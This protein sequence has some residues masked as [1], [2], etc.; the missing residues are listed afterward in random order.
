MM[1]T[2]LQ[3]LPTGQIAQSLR[4][5]EGTEL[6]EV[7]AATIV[8]VDEIVDPSSAWYDLDAGAVVA[9]PPRPSPS[10][11]FDY[12]AKA[13]I[14]PRT[15][16]ALRGVAHARIERWRD[17]QE[18]AGIVFEH[19]GHNWD[20]GL[21]TRQRLMP[22]LSLPALPEGFFW[23]D[24][25]NQDVPMDL[26]ALQALAAAHEGAI[27]QRGFA[28]HIRQRQMKE[29]LDDMTAAELDAFAPDWPAQP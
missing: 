11:Q 21:A 23:T 9:I 8:V 17:Q 26:S 25:D 3:V 27:V 22:V 1:R 2:Y 13:W 28:I 12:A 10:H 19:D 16:L 18:G 14:D 20:G 15:L 5:P 4:A 6:V 7:P 29:A 24:A